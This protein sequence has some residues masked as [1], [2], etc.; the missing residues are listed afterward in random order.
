MKERGYHQ[1]KRSL[2]WFVTLVLTAAMF[3]G[4]A[5]AAG[6]LSVEQEKFIVMPFLTYHAGYVYAQVKNTGDKPVEFDGGLLE[7]YDKEGNSIESTHR[8][9]C[10]PEVLAAGETGYAYASQGVEA[11]AETSFIDDY[12][13]TITGKGAKGRSAV[14]LPVTNKQYLE[15]KESYYEYTNISADVEN[16][17]DATVRG[18][19]VVFALSDA[20]GQLLY[21]TSCKPSYIGIKPGSS[22]EVLTRV[23]TAITEYFAAN[24]I[25]PSTVEAIACFILEAQ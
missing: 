9:I 19:Y 25:K 4:T 2:C 18:F 3:T 5:L 15:V 13:L 8:I 7:M 23:D 11:A 14:Y 1:M 21:V 24:S 10:C 22:V 12:L 6:K 16:T 20:Q 17:T